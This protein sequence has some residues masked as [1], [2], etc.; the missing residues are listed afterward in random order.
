M[1]LK[2]L[3]TVTVYRQQSKPIVLKNVDVLTFA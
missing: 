2:D 1:T 3:E